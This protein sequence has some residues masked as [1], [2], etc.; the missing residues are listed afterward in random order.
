MEAPFNR[1]D[2]GFTIIS[3]FEEI[4]RSFLSEKLINIFGGNFLDGVPKGIINKLKNNILDATWEDPSEFL[5][6]T[7]F[8]DLMEIV[9]YRNYY[10]HYFLSTSLSKNDFQISMVE[11]YNLRCK[12]A[13][14]RGYFTASDLDFLHLHAKRIADVLEDQNEVFSNF[15]QILKEHPDQVVIPIPNEFIVDDCLKSAIPNNLPVPDYEYEG[16]FVGRKEDRNNLTKLLEG[17]RYP[18][19]TLSGAGGVGKT[20]LALKITKEL[21]VK[22]S[23]KFDGIVWLSAKEKELSYLGIE[24]IEPTLKNHE[25]LLDAI[26]EVMGFDSLNLKHDEKD[27]KVNAIFEICDCILIVIDNLET[28]TDDR[29]IDFILEANP[30]LKIFITSRR[31]LGQVERRYELKQLKEKEAVF[32]FRQ[33]AKDKNLEKLIRLDDDILKRYVNQVSCYPLSI[34]WVIGQVAIG[35][36]INEVIDAIHET[37]SDI[38]KFCFE[39]IYGSL[40]TNPKKIIC[41]L[42]CFDTPPSAGVLKYAVDLDKHS[43]EDGIQDLILVSLVIPEQFKTDQNDIATRYSLLSLTRGY[44]REQLDDDSVL[45]R[46]L[47]ERLQTIEST[48]EVA[49][50]AKKHYRFSLSD[51]GASTEE[52]K[53]AAM[54][55][56]TAYQKY[57]AG[58][59]PDALDDYKKAVEI[60]PRFANL[61][62]NWAFVESQEGHLL[63][64]DRLMK[65][66]TALN[67]NDPSI[68][69]IWGNMLRKF[70][71]IKEALQKYQK[72]Y[73]LDPNDQIILNS[74]GQAKTRLGDYSEADKLFKVAIKDDKKSVR[75]EIINRSSIAENL[76]R[77][78]EKLTEDRNY[79]EAEAKLEEALQE[80]GKT[81]ALDK[82]DIKS[83]DQFRKIMI[84]LGRHYELR[85]NN[86]KEALIYYKRSIIQKPKRYVE[87]RDAIKASYYVA[88]ILY[89]QGDIEEAQKFCSPKLLSYTPI[90]RNP[91]LKEKYLSLMNRLQD[92]AG[93]AIIG[94]IIRVDTERGFVIIESTSSPGNTY[95]GHISDFAK[96]VDLITE[97]YVDKKV[98]FIPEETEIDNKVN[99]RAK[100]I[101]LQKESS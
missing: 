39:Q 74:Y 4:F 50:R 33:I 96:Y 91:K 69:L 72:A 16:G 94:K 43:F 80:S 9:C 41:A 18:V 28:I 59:Y 86:P 97:S 100:N 37:T 26:I 89:L 24:D 8:P 87:A 70:D 3:R 44:V 77:W 46:N 95:L 61:Y 23:Q 1:R 27:A 6:E 17:D 101:L 30:K 56:R 88:N 11:L 84:D 85:K 32:M 63:D 47:S 42:S 15:M 58:R 7:D 83:L 36:D 2:I 75:H 76:R 53:V 49:E 81:I 22:D 54:I 66:A 71:K 67:P 13:H 78:A 20:A 55:E 40:A 31:G 65:K 62:R 10:Q 60:A 35:K 79:T 64:A 34:K 73:A 90:K 98:T 45:K 19:I 68:W 51:L 52:E 82:N 21:L 92:Y 5:E 99:K 25:E 57:T 29:I 48:I 93:E 12:I 38:S 14:V